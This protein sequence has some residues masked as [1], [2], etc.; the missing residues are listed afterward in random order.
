MFMI[1][2]IIPASSIARENE[3]QTENAPIAT[4]RM[5]S[6]YTSREPEQTMHTEHP[7]SDASSASASCTHQSACTTTP[8]AR[9]DDFEQ[10]PSIN[11]VRL[12]RML[13]PDPGKLAPRGG[14]SHLDNNFASRN[15]LPAMGTGVRSTGLVGKASRIQWICPLTADEWVDSGAG[16]ACQHLLPA[17]TS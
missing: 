12:R 16:P 1:R 6:R 15:I 17:P 3:E 4:T 5:L 9:A 11:L 8:S 13:E 7:S 2:G 14:S 10:T